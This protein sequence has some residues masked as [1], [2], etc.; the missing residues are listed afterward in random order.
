M[1]VSW[2]VNMRTSLSTYESTWQA[3][4][5]VTY[6]CT[7]TCHTWM[8]TYMSMSIFDRWASINPRLHICLYIHVSMSIFEDMCTHVYIPPCIHWGILDYV[9]RKKP[10][11]PGVFPIYYVPSSRT[12]NKRTLLEEFVPGSARGVLLLTVLDEAT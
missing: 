7:R 1:S 11:P 4:V 3:H 10:P 5:Y 6:E 12:V 2:D 8:H 9:N